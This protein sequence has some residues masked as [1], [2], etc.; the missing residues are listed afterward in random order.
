MLIRL[1]T[2]IVIVTF[3]VFLTTP[4]AFAR[5]KCP[6][7]PPMKFSLFSIASF[8]ASTVASS[9]ATGRTSNTSGCGKGHP[10]DSFYR[11]SG[12]IFLDNNLEEV[13]ED[14]SRGQGQYL[15]A[16]ANLAGCERSVHSLFAQS[17]QE[18]YQ[19]LFFPPPSLSHTEQSDE[20]WHNVTALIDQTPALQKACVISS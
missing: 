11:P 1:Q 5:H 6:A 15:E 3:I 2:C 14:S 8:I 17:L 7:P 18:H 20:V 16:L 4:S 12:A 9:I 19:E 13:S 10:S